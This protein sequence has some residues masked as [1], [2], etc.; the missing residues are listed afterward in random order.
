MDQVGAV[1]LMAHLGFQEMLLFP[2][3]CPWPTLAWN[4]FVSPRFSSA[5]CDLFCESH[6]LQTTQHL[7]K[8]KEFFVKVDGIKFRSLDDDQSR[9]RQKH[10]TDLPDEIGH[11]SNPQQTVDCFYFKHNAKW[12]FRYLAVFMLFFLPNCAYILQLTVFR[13]EPTLVITFSLYFY[14][15]KLI[16]LFKSYFIILL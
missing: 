15:F 13:T 10:V 12:A 2:V 3:G 14:F 1:A 9:M 16:S 5:L 6:H 8:G 4:L 7:C 11:Q